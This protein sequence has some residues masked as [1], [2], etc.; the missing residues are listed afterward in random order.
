[1]QSSSV[2]ALTLNTH[3]NMAEL[4]ELRVPVLQNERPHARLV[5]ETLLRQALDWACRLES[6]QA[7]P[8]ELSLSFM[9]VRAVH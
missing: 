8:A 2:T 9:K 3:F 6:T 1:M 7:K 5:C 4:V